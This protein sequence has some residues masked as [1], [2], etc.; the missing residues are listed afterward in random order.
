MSFGAGATGFPGGNVDR[1]DEVGE[2][3]FSGTDMPFWQKSLGATPAQARQLLIA[4]LREMFE[5]AG[6]L[7]ARTACGGHLVDSRD[8]DEDRARIESHQLSFAEFLAK[9]RLV[10]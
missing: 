2:Q 5:E 10:P 6:I 9:Y 8:F 1:T 7:F 4:A 3:F